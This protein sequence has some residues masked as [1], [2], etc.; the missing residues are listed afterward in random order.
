MKFNNVILYIVVCILIIIGLITWKANGFNKELQ[1]STRSQIQ[2]SNKTGIEISELNKMVE[3]VLGNKEFSIQ[4]VEKFGNAVLINVKTITEEQKN[5]IIEKFNEKYGTELK[6][7]DI[8]V[9]EIPLTRVKDLVL[10]YILPGVLTFVMVALYSLIR[11][12]KIGLKTVLT[13][14]VC[15]PLAI[16][17]LLF[18]IIAITRIPLGRFQIGLAISIYMVVIAYLSK[19]FEEEREKINEI[20]EL[21]ND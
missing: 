5:S 13:R 10:P 8:K 21:A 3:E 6:S 11:F 2:L 14:I 16:E 19:I 17:L 4:E 12:K 1:Y 15:I 18:S 20:D 7:E 9:T